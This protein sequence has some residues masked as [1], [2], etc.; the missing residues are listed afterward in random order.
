MII[1]F[2]TTQNQNTE[3]VI[4]TKEQKIE[5]YD[6]ILKNIEN[7]YTNKIYDTSKLDKGKDDL[8]EIEK[9]IIIST[10]TQNQNKETVTKEEEIKY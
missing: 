8:I 9:M 7:T 3:R 1:A 6:T 10:T 5:Y 2:T 4:S